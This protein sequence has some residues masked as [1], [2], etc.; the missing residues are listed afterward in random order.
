MPVLLVPRVFNN[1]INLTTINHCTSCGAEDIHETLKSFGFFFR[2]QREVDICFG[3]A[4]VKMVLLALLEGHVNLA[5][6]RYIGLQRH[7]VN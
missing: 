4:G 3:V 1:L 2:G 7:W 5:A 6:D